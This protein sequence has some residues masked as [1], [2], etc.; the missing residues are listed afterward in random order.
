MYIRKK[1]I[2]ITESTIKQRIYNHKLS[3]SNRN[4][5]TDTCLSTHIWHQKDM[6][7]SPTIT[8]EILKL[9]H[10]YSKKT[11]KCLRCLHEKLAVITHPSQ[12]TL[13]NKNKKFYPNADMRTNIYFYKST[14]THNPSILP[15]LSPLLKIPP[16]HTWHTVSTIFLD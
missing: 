2:G 11:K 1:Y 6:N 3:F 10:V 5:S 14:Y 9:A 13:L 4:Y 8:W 12:N 15:R 7:I 16:R